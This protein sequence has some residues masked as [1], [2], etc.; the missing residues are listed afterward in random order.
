MGSAWIDGRPVELQT[1]CAEAARLLDQSRLPLIAGLGT[2]IAGARAAIRLAQRL[3]GVIDHM[4]SD[5]L[6]RDLDV[7]REAQMMVTTPA[8]A[9]LRADVLLLVGHVAAEALAALQAGNGETAAKKIVWLCPGRGP[10]RAMN[11]TP[12]LTI[13]RDPAELPAILA[14]LRATVAGRPIGPAPVGPKP[15]AQAAAQLKAAHFG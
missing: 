8:E 6:L 14:A 15:L 12:A 2:D 9:R 11:V 1:A 13:G 4:H 5:A 3:G 10:R 7:M